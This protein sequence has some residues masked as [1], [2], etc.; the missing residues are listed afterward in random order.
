MTIPEIASQLRMVIGVCVSADG[1]VS[2]TERRYFDTFQR[3]SSDEQ[4]IP[5]WLSVS[6]LEEHQVPMFVVRHWAKRSSNFIE[7]MALL[8]NN[9]APPGTN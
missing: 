9:T 5:F 3:N 2:P 4:V 6:S 7:W 1:N 8:H